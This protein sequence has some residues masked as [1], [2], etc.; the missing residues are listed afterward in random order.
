M[1]RHRGRRASAAA[2]RDVQDSV[3]GAIPATARLPAPQAPA[4]LHRPATPCASTPG[5]RSLADTRRGRLAQVL[6]YCK[7]HTDAKKAG[8]EAKVEDMKAFDTDFVK[9]DQGTLFE[10]ILVRR[11]RGGIGNA[12]CR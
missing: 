1:C 11:G 5:P 10:L 12:L 4:P 7:Y 2:E 6:E 9:V 3:E 8:T